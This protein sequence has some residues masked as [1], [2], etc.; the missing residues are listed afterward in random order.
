MAMAILV[1]LSLFNIRKR[2][3]EAFLLSHILLSTAIIV[4]TF[5]HLYFLYR[6]RI[7]GFELYL[8]GAV[9]VWLLDR[10]VR[11][12][13]IAVNGLKTATITVLDEDYI[14]IDIPTVRAKGHAYLYFP[15]LTWRVWENHPFSVVS[16]LSCTGTLPDT[17]DKAF[18]LEYPDKTFDGGQSSLKI[19]NS[20]ELQPSPGS[21][22]KKYLDILPTKREIVTQPWNIAGGITSTTE[23]KMTAIS[24][25]NVS[26]RYITAKPLHTFISAVALP[27][28]WSKNWVRWS[29][30]TKCRDDEGVSF[31]LRTFAGSTRLLRSRTRL[32]VLIES[33]YGIPRDLSGHDLL[34]CI[35]GGVGIT[36]VLPHLQALRRASS[37]LS[38]IA[39]LSLAR[40]ST[41][42]HSMTSNV[43]ST[44][45]AMVYWSCR[46]A[47]LVTT[48]RDEVA[49]YPGEVLV[50]S[51]LDVSKI[52]WREIMGVN[53]TWKVVVSVSGPRGMA[54]DARRTVC[55]IARVRRKG[56]VTFVDERFGW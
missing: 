33:N 27:R 49:P 48:L 1:L 36:A 20:P 53:E 34:I 28:Q 12:I 15:T 10:V 8:W 6:S 51:R 50:G 31:F 40:T 32:P 19:M 47:P 54:D 42:G 16:E 43:H 44:C 45:H 2:L 38:S 9:V 52:L 41:Y 35:A 26:P 4:G 55:E 56:V 14:R 25:D 7:T 3:Y 22:T 29:D 46:S 23:F 11:I 24:L 17:P 39:P 13:R 21:T 18:G 37:R 30:N 5:Y